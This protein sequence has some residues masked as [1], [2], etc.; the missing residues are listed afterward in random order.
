MAA[1]GRRFRVVAHG[2]VHLPQHDVREVGAGR[3]GPGQFE[4][5]GTEPGPD[6]VVVVGVEQQRREVER[7]IT[8]QHGRVHV[9]HPGDRR[10]A[11][12]QVGGGEVVMH[13][14]GAGRDGRSAACPDLAYHP[15]HVPGFRPGRQGGVHAV[16]VFALGQRSGEQ[17]GPVAGPRAQ[18]GLRVVQPDELGQQHGQARQAGK[19]RA[20][21]QRPA[22]QALLD[23]EREAGRAPDGGDLSCRVVTSAEPG[24]HG[25]E[26]TQLGDQPGP[27]VPA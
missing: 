4:Q 21:V 14:I 10:G 13:I 23:A 7:A 20:Q 16:S 2:P 6:P 18:A 8:G 19:A 26:R 25:L 15:Q 27:T 24:R 11:G 1:G 12:E 9:D 3:L 22:G 5:A 17:R